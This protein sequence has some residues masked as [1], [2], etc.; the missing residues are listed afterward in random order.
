MAYGKGT[1]FAVKASYS[2][3]NTFSKP[4][5]N[6]KKHMYYVRVLTGVYT[7][8]YKT[9]VEPPLKNP[10]NPMDPDRY[11]TATDNERNPSLFVVFY[12][13]QSYPEFLITFKQ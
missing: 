9:L 3:S 8:G 13:H 1:Y 6:G 12:D 11:D 2:A 5:T 7:R 10:Q 4:D